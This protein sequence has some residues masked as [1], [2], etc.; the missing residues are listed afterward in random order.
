MG[1]TPES[2][3]PAGVGEASFRRFIDENPH[4]KRETTALMITAVSVLFK[5]IEPCGTI[6]LP[7][8]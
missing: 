1:G 6:L 4:K 7:I 5:A 3:S 8:L 2:K